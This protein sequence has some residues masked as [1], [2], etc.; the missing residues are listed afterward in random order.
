VK[1]CRDQNRRRGLQFADPTRNGAY[2]EYIVVRE[3]ETRRS[4]EVPSS[5]P[6]S[7]RAFGCAD[8]WQSLF[9][10]AH[11]GPG[12]RV[13]IHAGAAGVAISPCNS[14]NGKARKFS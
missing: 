8:G 7:G 11:C 13:L 12:Q 2:A 10:T 1:A 6:R 3:S 4:T 5:H 9:D 14:Q